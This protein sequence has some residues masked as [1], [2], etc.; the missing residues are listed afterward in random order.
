MRITKNELNVEEN[1]PYLIYKGSLKDAKSDLVD[2]LRKSQKE[3][4]KVMTSP[5]AHIGQ[6]MK[7]QF[8][9]SNGD[10]SIWALGQQKGKEF[11]I[12]T[13]GDSTT[14]A[15]LAHFFRVPLLVCDK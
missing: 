7:K 3:N 6:L 9:I 12:M 1:E 13:K 14:H 10:Y 4:Y 11:E 5:Q 15:Y 8:I 2:L